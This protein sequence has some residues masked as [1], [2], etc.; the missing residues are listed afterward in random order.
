MVMALAPSTAVIPARSTARY[1]DWYLSQ[2]LI[3]ELHYGTTVGEQLVREARAQ[4]N[5]GF[6][7]T[8]G[9]QGF[10]S[11]LSVDHLPNVSMLRLVSTRNPVDLQA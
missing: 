10:S 1:S 2:Y 11:C 6:T 7:G 5:V 8:S 4:L 9:V 3:A